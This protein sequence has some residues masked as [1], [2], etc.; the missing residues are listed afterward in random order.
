VPKAPPVNI[1]PFIVVLVIVIGIG[2]YAA[3]SSWIGQ[4]MS[5]KNDVVDPLDSMTQAQ[6]RDMIENG[7][8]QGLTAVGATGKITY[9]VEGKEADKTVNSPVEMTIDTKLQSPDQ[10]KAVIEPIKQYMEKARIPT[11]VMND[12]KSRANWTYQVTLTAPVADDSNELGTAP[13]TSA[14]PAQ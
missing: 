7:I 9:M 8:T 6:A 1:M 12:S 3:Q 14:P 11:L 5:H 4:V 13:A 2:I 10:H